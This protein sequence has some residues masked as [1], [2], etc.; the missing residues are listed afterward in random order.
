MMTLAAALTGNITA[1]WYEYTLTV[2]DRFGNPDNDS[3][4]HS[5]N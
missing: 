4:D 5:R 1:N 3:S 2:L